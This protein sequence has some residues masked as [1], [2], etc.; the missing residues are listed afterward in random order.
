MKNN[1]INLIII[2]IAIVK[3]NYL[4]LRN[5]FYNRFIIYS[6]MYNSIHNIT[7]RTMELALGISSDAKAIIKLILCET[8]Q[9]VIN[10]LPGLYYLCTI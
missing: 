7:H 1:N 9:I 5:V 2:Y 3:F 8:L 6:N 4:L 10:C